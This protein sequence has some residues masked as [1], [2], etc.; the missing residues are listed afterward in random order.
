MGGRDQEPLSHCV[1]HCELLGVGVPAAPRPMGWQQAHEWEVM[2]GGPSPGLCSPCDMEAKRVH[3]TCPQ[4]Q[5]ERRG[6]PLSE[7][8]EAAPRLVAD[9]SWGWRAVLLLQFPPTQG[10]HDNDEPGLGWC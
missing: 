2:R 10:C 3:A 5:A 1:T 9:L 4:A 8:E 7:Q 6:P